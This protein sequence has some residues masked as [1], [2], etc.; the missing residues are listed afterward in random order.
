MV[1]NIGG[2]I[3]Y[4]LQ[5]KVY[6]GDWILNLETHNICLLSKWLFKLLNEDG[7]WQNVL[8]GKYVKNKCITQMGRRP[9][10]SHF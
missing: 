9:G 7:M 8:R 5:A 3:K 6:R 1:K 2:K 4:S 10:D